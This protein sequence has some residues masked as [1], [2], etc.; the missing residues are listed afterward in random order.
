MDPSLTHLA[1]HS[2][3]VVL[4]LAGAAAF[5]V[6]FVSR[7][8]PAQQYGALSL[9][10]AGA[11][12]PAAYLSGRWAAAE[13][14]SRST[15]VDARAALPSVLEAHALYGLLATLALIAVGVIA[16][17]WLGRGGRRLGLVLVALAVLAALLSAAA[18]RT[19]GFILHDGPSRPP[20]AAWRF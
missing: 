8:A 13:V 11:T 17:V 20:P 12:A 18:G 4:A 5:L 15:G 19:G 3:P 1:V 2:F 16:G 14:A 10:L 6:G 9:L 7:W